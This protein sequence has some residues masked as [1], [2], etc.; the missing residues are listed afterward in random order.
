MHKK[1]TLDN[2]IRLLMANS[3][4]TDTV[5]VTALVGI[6]SKYETKE[7]SGIPIFGAFAIQGNRQAPVGNG[8]FF[9][10]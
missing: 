9:G 2:G 7:I 10:D 1:I 5:A 8:D 6:G 4:N 3:R